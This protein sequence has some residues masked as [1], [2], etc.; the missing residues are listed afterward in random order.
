MLLRPPAAN[1]IHLDAKLG[2]EKGF[3]KSTLVFFFL[4]CI[5]S[6]KNCLPSPL[7]PTSKPQLL[8]SPLLRLRQSRSSQAS[9]SR[10]VL[11]PEVSCIGDCILSLLTS[12]IGDRILSLL[13][14][15]DNLSCGASEPRG[16]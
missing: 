4:F 15:P 5:K 12:C 2:V 7:A 13:K 9:E 11:P 14:Q 8:Q 10:K 1:V 3:G 16:L 6:A